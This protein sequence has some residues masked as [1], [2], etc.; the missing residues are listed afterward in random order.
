MAETASGLQ[1]PSLS[2]AATTEIDADVRLP[3]SRLT[4][5]YNAPWWLFLLIIVALTV[6]LMIVED[7][8]YANIFDQLKAG[9]GMTLAVSIIAY[10]SAAM[11]GL[12]VGIIRSTSPAPPKPGT[13]VL[14]VVTNLLRTVLYN[15]VTIYV[16]LLRGLPPLVIIL[17]AAFVLVPIIRDFL[18]SALGVDL[19][20]WRGSSPQSAIA[21]LAF[22]YGAFMS[23]TFRAGIQSINKGQLEAARSLGMNY[24]QTMRFVVLPQAIRTILPPLGNDLVSMIKDSSLVSILGVRDMTQIAKTSVGRSFLYTQTYTVLAMM[25]LTMTVI[26]SLLVRWL[27]RHL[28]QHER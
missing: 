25:Y 7:P 23:E 22:M 2:E 21:A 13:P 4:L 19:S 10:I 1:P 16:Q 24:S 17:I 5:F 26:G 28:K 6:G 11:I 9:V 8:Q 12:M 27:E 18:S 20:E 15:L 14:G 3:Q